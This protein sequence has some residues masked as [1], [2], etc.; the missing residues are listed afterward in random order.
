MASP[1]DLVKV[2]AATTGED[3][4]TITQHDR[5]LLIAGLRTKGGRGRSGQGNRP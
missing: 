5:N 1:G 2:I 4:A 3:E